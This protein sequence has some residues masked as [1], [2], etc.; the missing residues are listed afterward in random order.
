MVDKVDYHT[1]NIDAAY[2]TV[3]VYAWS[4]YPKHSV[5][6]GQARKIYVQS[7]STIE[8]AHAAYPDA[9]ISS[10]WTEPQVNLNHLPG[11]DD[12]VAGGMYPDDINDGY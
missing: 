5:L 4:T 6:A 7:Y 12:P 2:G 9:N 11:E 8:E 10:K 1:I 3:S